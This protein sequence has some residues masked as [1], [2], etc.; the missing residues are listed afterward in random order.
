[1]IKWIL[2]LCALSAAGCSSHLSSG[3]ITPIAN[4][5]GLGLAEP[6]TRG[7]VTLVPVVSLPERSSR[8]ETESYVLLAEA[9]ENGWV[10]VSEVSSSGQ[11]ELVLVRNL[12]AKPILLLAGDILLGGKQDRVVAKDTIVLPGQSAEVRVFCV[13]RGR[14]GGN[15]VEFDAPAASAPAK[16]RSA[17]VL[18]GQM[19]VWD[20]VEQHNS[21]AELPGERSTSIREGLFGEKARARSRADLDPLMSQLSKRSDVVGALIVLDG[22]IISLELFG[23]PSLFREAI[24]PIL[25]GVLA[26]AATSSAQTET[27][28]GMDE[29]VAFVESVMSAPR[30]Q[31]Y[32]GPTSRGDGI[33]S[34][35][36]SGWETRVP[37][38]ADAQ[39]NGFIRGSYTPKHHD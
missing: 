13:E 28:I 37:G 21:S 6:I 31:R 14:W 34:Q 7:N 38:E 26:Q 2:F 17:A 35:N 15:S 11:V 27:T 5:S 19:D 39:V 24:R 18:G 4:S 33:D 9:M 32:A 22:K 12:G 3:S 20:E 16:V 23:S 10:E 8:Q 30:S 25:T 36:V 1:M 29:Y